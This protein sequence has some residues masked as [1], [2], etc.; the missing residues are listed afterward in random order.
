[1]R[2]REKECQKEGGRESVACRRMDKLCSRQVSW[3]NFN[4]P[5]LSIPA[6]V[7]KAFLIQSA[8]VIIMLL[9][10]KILIRTF[11]SLIFTSLMSALERYLQKLIKPEAIFLVVCDPS[12]NELL[13]P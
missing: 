10:L 11:V 1:M 4:V 13:V 2:K 5:A 8:C 12:M 6:G 3:T 9:L 7:L